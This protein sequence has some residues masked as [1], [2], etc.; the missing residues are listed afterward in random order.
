[1]PSAWHMCSPFAQAR[2]LTFG[3]GRYEQQVSG[4]RYLCTCTGQ[5]LE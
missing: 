1:M 5:L 3:F 2:T 4:L